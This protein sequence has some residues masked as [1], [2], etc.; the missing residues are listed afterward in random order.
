MLLQLLK[1]DEEEHGPRSTTAMVKKNALVAKMKL[2]R[3]DLP[4][5]Q[6]MGQQ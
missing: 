3:K 1:S 6:G 5:R 4:K 2:E